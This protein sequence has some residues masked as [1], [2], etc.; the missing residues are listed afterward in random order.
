MRYIRNKLIVVL[1]FLFLILIPLLI[2]FISIFNFEIDFNFNTLK[3]I[4]FFT[5][6]QATISTAFSLVVALP[7]AIY[8]GKYKSVFNKLIKRTSIIP[9][10]FP[11]ISMTISFLAIYG[12][13]GVIN[14]I[15]NSLNF[16]RVQFL[17]TFFIII[18]AHVFYN[19]PI[20]VKT[21]S[22]G[23]ERYPKNLFEESLILGV[24]PVKKFFK[25][26]L[27]FL[28]T[29]IISGLILVFSYSFTSFAVVM[30]LG[31][32]QY[33]TLEVSIYMYLKLLGKPDVAILISMIQFLF[34]ILFGLLINIL[35]KEYPSEGYLR[36]KKKTKN[37]FLRVYSIFYSFFEWVPVI[38]A[39][40]IPFYNFNDNS[41]TI[42]YFLNLFTM[43]MN[44]II[45]VNSILSTVFNSFIFSTISGIAST[46]LAFYIIL[47]IKIKRGNVKIIRILSLISISVSPVIMALAYSKAYFFIS[48]LISIVLLYIVLTFPVNI[49]LIYSFASKFDYSIIESSKIDGAKNSD[50]IRKIALPIFKLPLIYTLSISFAICFGEISAALILISDVLPTLPV[51]IYRLS[52][53][54]YLGEARTASSLLLIIVLLSVGIISYLLK[55]AQHDENSHS[56]H[57]GL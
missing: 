55:R 19:S 20:L 18:V 7:V 37:I 8:I 5:L 26:E 48:P 32:S 33:A 44:S 2:T 1:I 31:G 15:L 51:A 45:G 57:R 35:D 42:K 23:Y 36:T 52:S 27:P 56:L 3:N 17:Y 41:F 47:A 12:R 34:L 40:I 25:L 4:L 28:L 50:I 16:S 46:A 30:I 22:E 38:I 9:F 11:S 10:F 21:I 13:Y 53:T 39:I 24:N 29:S 6:K 54:R 14:N 43:N 49:N